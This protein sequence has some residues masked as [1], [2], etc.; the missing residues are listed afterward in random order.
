MPFTRRRFLAQLALAAFGVP[1]VRDLAR[2]IEDAGR[3]LLL[4]P[5]AA[6]QDLHIYDG[7]YV[8]LGPEYQASLNYRPTWREILKLEGVNVDDPV[9]LTTAMNRRAM[10]VEELEAPVSDVC[11]PM[12]EGSLWCPAARAANL[13]SRL[14]LG[15]K[16]SGLGAAGRIEFHEGDNHPGSTDTWA[17]V[18]DDL[19]ASLLQAR[20]I[21]LRQPLRVVIEADQGTIIALD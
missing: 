13:L 11:W 1:S 19:S 7:G 4:E 10:E 9:E 5:P 2:K 12:V 18:P 17:V 3:P 21:E 16:L 15:S 8:T 20:L 6:S 14:D